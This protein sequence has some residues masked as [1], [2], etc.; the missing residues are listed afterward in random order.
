MLVNAF[1][2]T[3]K[4][5]EVRF[6]VEK[7]AGLITFYVWNEGVIPKDVALRVFQPHFSTRKGKGRGFGAFSMKLLGEEFLSGKV[8]FTSTKGEGTTFRFSLPTG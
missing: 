2:A 4:N 6:W 7:D 5:G 8:D 1:E 3:E